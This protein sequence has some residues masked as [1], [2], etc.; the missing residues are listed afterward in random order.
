MIY[1]YPKKGTIPL[2]VHMM[3]TQ[4]FLTKALQMTADM[5]PTLVAVHKIR[6]ERMLA[7]LSE[8]IIKVEWNPENNPIEGEDDEFAGTEQE[9]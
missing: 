3:Q 5:I 9:F 6:R 1:N 8:P 2:G 4:E 7:R